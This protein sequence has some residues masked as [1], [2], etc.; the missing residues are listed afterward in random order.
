[1][2]E[3]DKATEPIP[4]AI[5]TVVAPVVLHE[6]VL[7]LPLTMVEGDPVKVEMTGGAGFTVTV[8]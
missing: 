4:G 7:L 8:A 6:S 3:P 5:E 1:M 2:L